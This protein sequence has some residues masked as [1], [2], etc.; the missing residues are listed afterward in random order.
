MSFLDRALF[1]LRSRRRDDTQSCSQSPADRD[2]QPTRGGHG[3]WDGQAGR[4]CGRRGRWKT[5]ETDSKH[6]PELTRVSVSACGA[7]AAI[8]AL[9]A[10]NCRRF[11]RRGQEERVS[12]QRSILAYFPGFGVLGLCGSPRRSCTYLG[13]LHE[14]RRQWICLVCVALHSH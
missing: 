11:I 9:C 1:S 7:Q 14:A 6:R 2:I 13:C 10:L 3:R 8:V 5:T 4:V 12:V